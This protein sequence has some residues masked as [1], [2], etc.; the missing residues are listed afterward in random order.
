VA[1]F[2]NVLLKYVLP[3]ALTFLM[4]YILYKYIPE[5]KVHTRA[6]LIPAAVAALFFEGFKRA[7]AFTSPTS[8]PSAS[9]SAASSR[10]RSPRSCSSCSG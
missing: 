4:F 9:S 6:G 3:S 2:N 10:A 7:F 5:T 1:A 8:R